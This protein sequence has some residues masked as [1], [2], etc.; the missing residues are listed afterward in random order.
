VFSQPLRG[1]KGQEAK[2][3][4][5]ARRALEAA[6]AMNDRGVRKKEQERRTVALRAILKDRTSK[7]QPLIQDNEEPM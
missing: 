1:R 3:V 4:I 7:S 5:W 6:M 2:E